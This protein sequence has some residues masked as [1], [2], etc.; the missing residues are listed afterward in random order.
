MPVE[1]IYVFVGK[2]SLALQVGFCI[3]KL[4]VGPPT[5]LLREILPSSLKG[6]TYWQTMY[7]EA[8]K[9]SQGRPGPKP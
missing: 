2:I 7:G 5:G 9:I 4:D 6:S 8:F 3:E 1:N